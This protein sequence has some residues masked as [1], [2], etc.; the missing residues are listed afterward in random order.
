[1]SSLMHRRVEL[2][3]HCIGTIHLTQMIPYQNKSGFTKTQT[4][5]GSKPFY[6]PL[7]QLGYALGCYLSTN[8]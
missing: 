3:I 5:L 7:A 8:Y 4:L 1:M 6:S 2:F